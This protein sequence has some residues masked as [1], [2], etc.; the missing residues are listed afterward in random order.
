VFK[1]LLHFVYTDRM[2]DGEKVIM[3]QHLLVAA[4][5]QASGDVR[6]QAYRIH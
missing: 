2:E 5:R 4:D 3:A 1:A 6:G